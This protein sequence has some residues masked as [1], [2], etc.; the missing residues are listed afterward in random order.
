LD[1][2]E[3]DFDDLYV[4]RIVENLVGNA[5]KAVHETIPDEWL[6]QHS[7]DDSETF[8][9][10]RIQ[11]RYTGES[12]I[13]IVS[14]DGPGMP[15]GMIRQILSGAASSK[16]EQSS[17][18]GL[19]TKVITDLVS[20]HGAKLSIRSKLG[21]GSSFEVDFGPGDLGNELAPES[22]LIATGR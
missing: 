15:P 10:V 2:P 19:G 1:A 14:D 3:F 4:I 6:G 16:W 22:A 7:G 5:I 21:E 11:Y 8:G 13:L 18:S 12:H 17:G 9:E 20:A